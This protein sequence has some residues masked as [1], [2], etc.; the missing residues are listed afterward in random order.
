[1]RSGGRGGMPRCSEMAP[2]F[3]PRHLPK[4]RTVQGSY[5]GDALTGN[6]LSDPRTLATTLRVDRPPIS[7][8][9][10]VVLCQ[11]EVIRCYCG[12]PSTRSKHS[13]KE[14]S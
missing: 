2:V 9:Y 3:G 13:L 1:M 5:R 4:R 7:R 11:E 14:D 10:G 6:T 8:Y 12:G